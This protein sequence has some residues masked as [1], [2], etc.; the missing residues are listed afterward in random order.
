MLNVFNLKY[1]LLFFSFT[2]CLSSIDTFSN[3]ID[4]VAKRKEIVKEYFFNN[5]KSSDFQTS[6]SKL[7][8]YYSFVDPYEGLNFYNEIVKNPNSLNTAHKKSLIYNAIALQYAKLGQYQIAAKYYFLSISASKEIPNQNQVALNYID[9]GNLY[10]KLYQYDEAIHYYNNAIKILD[11]LISITKEEKKYNND[12]KDR[13]TVANENIG[14]C[15][16]NLKKYD[17]AVV[18]VKK[19]ENVRLA[20]H[21]TVINKQYYFTTL[22]RLYFSAKKYDSAIFYSK[23]SLDF[24][25]EKLLTNADIPEHKLFKSDAQLIIGQ[26]YFKLNQTDL[27]LEFFDKALET[28]KYFKSANH[29][30]AAYNIII[31][32]LLQEN[33]LEDAKKYINEARKLSDKNPELTDKKYAL[34]KLAAVYYSK[35]N[36]PS[37]A[38]K[39]QDTIIRY[40]DSIT[41]RVSAENI[42]IARIDVEL[43]NNLKTIEALNLEKH[44]KDQEIK[45][46]KTTIFLFILI[47]FFFTLLAAVI[48]YFYLQRQKLN[49]QLSAKNEELEKLNEKLSLALK[50]TEE[51]NIELLASQYE[52]KKINESL[53]IANKT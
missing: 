30:L 8:E 52:L 37:I 33:F 32:F 23:K 44:Y 36:N 9:L 42:K 40:L 2:I 27:A 1:F 49:K 48:F 50:K 4:D 26:S 18:Y 45:N 19:N 11:S 43:Q 31:D 20:A 16:L 14:L 28:R 46:Q 25:F 21:Q 39:I 5:R 7:R 51:I 41:Q 10:Y 3:K 47:A 35:I 29:L 38:K 34:L 12:L 22:G 53:E 15:L 24:D 6:F 17:S 13:L